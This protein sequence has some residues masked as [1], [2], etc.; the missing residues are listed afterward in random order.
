M[1]HDRIRSCLAEAGYDAELAP[2]GSTLTLGFEVGERRISL[3]HA[4][5]SQLLRVPKFH[6]ADGYA[7]KLAHVGV[8]R[9]DG[10]GEVCIADEGST[11]VNTDRPELVYLETVQKHVALLTRLIENS[12]YNRAEQLREFEA[13]WEILCRKEHKGLNELFVAW[14]GHGAE[15]LQV[16]PAR[17][18]SGTDLRKTPIALAWALAN[19]RQLSS[20]QGVAEWESRPAVGKGLAVRVSGLEP[21][22]TSL[23]ELLPW[24]FRAVEQ[25]DV[26]DR[27]E[28]RRLGKK[29]SRDYWLVFAAPIPDGETMFAIR[30]HSRS[31]GPLPASGAEAEA[32]R[33]APTPYRVRSLSRGSVVPRGGGS[34][35][36]GKKSVLLIGCGSVG[37]ELAMRLTSA[38]V[39][40]LTASDPDTF[41]EENLYRHVLSVKDIGRLKT[42]ALARAMALRHPWAELT[43]WCKRLEELRDPTVLQQFD[44]VVIAIGSPTVE[45]VFAEYC[46]HENVGVPVINCWLE[47]YGIGGHAILVMP[48]AKGCWHCAYVD[49]QTLTRALTSN[50]NFLKPGQ[51]VMRNLGGCG[52]QFLP[53]S[54]IAA[55]CT[56]TM[57]ADLSV[58][59][60]AGEVTTSSKVSWKGGDAEAMRASREVTWRYRHFGE[61]LRILPL[62]NE[63]CDLCG[64]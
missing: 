52:T 3:V 60:L 8:S 35:E 7:G 15:G 16:K 6:L 30:W 49:P 39:G 29:S 26:A 2:D 23:D 36:L 42:V 22:P 4:F 55:S 47:G 43:S 40:R 54:G 57:A 32:G 14:D 53:Y 27:R 61:S 62:H 37:G 9:S 13:H 5:P 64:G 59:F 1:N 34:L 51:V 12:A 58:R 24:Y 10:S 25:V 11:A 18:D 21:V 41:S 48:G 17:A 56:A 19:H 31:A 50:L 63:N 28:L 44:L 20:V 38:G 46:R 45:R 33:W